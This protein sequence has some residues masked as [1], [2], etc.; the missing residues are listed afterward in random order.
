[1]KYHSIR[2]S[3]EAMTKLATLAEPFVDTPNDVL[4]RV[5]NLDKPKKNFVA[6][7]P[8]PQRSKAIRIDAEVFSKLE[9]A[10]KL[11]A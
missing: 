5:L 11:L 9:R 7:V 3:S 8:L 10:R 4:R 1:M 6:G 2:L